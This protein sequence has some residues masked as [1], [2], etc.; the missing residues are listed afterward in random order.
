MLS[1][2][3]LYNVQLKRVK[4]FMGTVCWEP[5]RRAQAI[6]GT[7]AVIRIVGPEAGSSDKP[8]TQNL[9]VFFNK[10]TVFLT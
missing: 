9:Q 5:D 2:F 3:E 10:T 1:S 8:N 6:A 4:H 7:K